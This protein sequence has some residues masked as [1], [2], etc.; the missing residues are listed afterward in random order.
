MGMMIKR[1]QKPVGLSVK[2]M[3]QHNKKNLELVLG[4]DTRSNTWDGLDAY[5]E[6]KYGRGRRPMCKIKESYLIKI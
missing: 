5:R 6:D 4:Q 2:P 3:K 1:D